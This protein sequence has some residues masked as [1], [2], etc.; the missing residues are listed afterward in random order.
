MQVAATMEDLDELTI[1]E[2][3]NDEAAQDESVNEDAATEAV[4]PP[5]AGKRI[6]LAGR[7]GGMNHREATN[8]LKSYDAIVVDRHDPHV[9]WIVIGA[10][11]PPMAETEWLTAERRDAAAAGDIEVLHE[12]EL[13]HRLGLVELEHAVR[14]YYTPAMLAHLLGVSVRVVRRW[15][16][17][18]LITPVR[19]LHRLPYFDFAEVATARRLAQWVAAGASPQA[20]ERRLAELVEYLPDLR[21]PLDQLNI[22]VEGKQILLRQGEGL[23]E[24]GGQLRIDFEAL[25]D[26]PPSA[27]DLRVDGDTILQM[28]S[29]E[30]DAFPLH[31]SDESDELFEAAFAAEDAGDMECA[32][33]FCHAILARDGPRADVCFQLGEMLYRGGELVAARERYFMAVELDPEFVEARASLGNVLAELGRLELAVAAFEGSLKLHED[34]PDVHFALAQTLEQLERHDEARFHWQRFRELAPHSPWVGEADRRLAVIDDELKAT[35]VGPESG[36]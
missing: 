2:P 31:D 16:R 35:E 15:Q 33:D 12:T 9:E 27:P 21:R 22:L 3:A 32:I 11:E 13:W 19:T 5:V 18:G 8:L 10:E 25:E 28:T 7:F 30:S 36:S 26:A 29:R 1:D 14:R 34:Y 17:L 6:A 24:P 20:I 23:I 4:A